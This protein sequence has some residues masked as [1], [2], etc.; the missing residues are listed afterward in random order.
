MDQAIAYPWGSAEPTDAHAY[1]VPAVL[2]NLPVGNGLSIADLGCGNG[3]LAGLLARQGHRVVAVDRSQSGI[4]HGQAQ[5]DQVSFHCAPIDAEL[6]SRIGSGFD[7]VL[8]TEVIEHLYAPRILIAVA[9]SLLR[10]GGTMILTTPY[11]G[12]VKNLALALTGLLD[13]HFTTTWDGGHIK[14]FSVRSLGKVVAEQHFT[15]IRF[16]FAGRCPLLWKSMVLHAQR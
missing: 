10:P 5:H 13:R 12:Y 15:D 16:S 2:K 7:V 9:H 11:H 4:C 1:L 8:A 14:F 6:P 3:Y